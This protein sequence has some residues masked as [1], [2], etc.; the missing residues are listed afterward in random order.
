MEKASCA[1]QL[2]HPGPPLASISLR[3]LAFMIRGKGHL[4][5]A[6]MSHPA[7]PSFCFADLT[8]SLRRRPESGSE[9]YPAFGLHRTLPLLSNPQS[10]SR[11]PYP[12]LWDC[13]SHS[14]ASRHLLAARAQQRISACP[15]CEHRVLHRPSQLI[16][17]L[18]CLVL[19]LLLGR[20]FKT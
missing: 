1:T 9:S 14:K 20:P 17:K 6:W 18:P 7:R 13:P 12:D 19:F 4:T 10:P 2:G 11:S 5:Q 15:T 3:E 16:L 8:A